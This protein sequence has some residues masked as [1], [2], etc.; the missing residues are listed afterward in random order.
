MHKP[1]LPRNAALRGLPAAAAQHNCHLTFILLHICCTR[2]AAAA[3]HTGRRLVICHDTFA[4]QEFRRLDSQ[5]G[6]ARD[7]AELLA[8]GELPLLSVTVSNGSGALLRERATLS[9]STN[10]VRAHG[11]QRLFTRCSSNGGVGVNN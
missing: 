10:Y 1:Q 4:L 8:G 7:R 5:L 6:A 9:T 11:R 2:P 3:A